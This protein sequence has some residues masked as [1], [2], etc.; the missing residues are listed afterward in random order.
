MVAQAAWADF[1]RSALTPKSARVFL[2]AHNQD[3]ILK[4]GSYPNMI[5]LKKTGSG[6]WGYQH[7]TDLDG[8]FDYRYSKTKRNML[9]LESKVG[10]IDVSAG[11][12]YERVFDPLKSLFP[13]VTFTYALFADRTHL[14]DKRYPEYRMLQ[15]APARIYEALRDKGVPSL[16]FEFVEESHVFEMMCR[17]LVTTYRSIKH[18]SVTI[19][20]TTTV[21]EDAITI[22]GPGAREPYMV[23]E[24]DRNGH[25]RVVRGPLQRS[26][27]SVEGST[28]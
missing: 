12:L 19:S 5:L 20:G 17:H 24:K 15:D 25:Y 7:I 14:F 10:K 2:V 18:Q 26:G 21:S 6:K 28:I 3:Y 23:L 1:F 4:I 8:L 16:F 27:T 9:I 22:Y 11:H 13:D